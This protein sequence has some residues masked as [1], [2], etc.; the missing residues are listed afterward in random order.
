MWQLPSS[1]NTTCGLRDYHLYCLKALVSITFAANLSS[2][3]QQ[4]RGQNFFKKV[5]TG[6]GT[7][8]R[9]SQ[10]TLNFVNT[11]KALSLRAKLLQAAC[12]GPP[13]HRP[14]RAALRR[15]HS[16]QPTAAASPRRRSHFRAGGLIS[17]AAIRTGLHPLPG[18]ALCSRHLPRVPPLAPR[19]AD[20][21][22]PRPPR[23]ADPA[24]PPPG[25][26]STG[27]EAGWEMPRR[28]RPSR[29]VP[30]L[31]ARRS[32]THHGAKNM[33]KCGAAAAPCRSISAL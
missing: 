10:Q 27:E 3:F 26:T 8:G 18:P 29:A 22:T 33:T 28:A 20:R 7:Q 2:H 19:K 13:S 30:C 12:T 1:A 21:A 5:S 17:G 25:A 9:E 23:R 15:P 14:D 31:P 16:A 32:D 6:P 24:R 4:Q 11:T